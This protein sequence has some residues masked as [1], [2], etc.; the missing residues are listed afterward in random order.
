MP[1]SQRILP[2]SDAWIEPNFKTKPPRMNPFQEGTRCAWLQRNDQNS[3]AYPK[4]D[5]I[6]NHAFSVETM[7]CVFV[8]K[9]PAQFVND[10]AVRWA[11]RAAMRS[12]HDRAKARILPKMESPVAFSGE[13][14]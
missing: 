2:R 4:V 11:E 13:C 8:L 12:L 5:P 9:T 14:R 6:S 1:P 3:H 10:V 7:Q